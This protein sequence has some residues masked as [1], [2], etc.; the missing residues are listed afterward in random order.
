[1]RSKTVLLFLFSCSL[2]LSCSSSGGG[3]DDRQQVQ[4]PNNPNSGNPDNDVPSPKAA[5]LIFPEHNTECNE[6]TNVTAT[7]SDVNFQWNLAADTDSY[8][9]YVENL[10]SGEV[11]M[12]N[13]SEDNVTMT[14]LRGTPFAWHVVSKASGTNA[15][16]SSSVAQFYNAGAP[17]Q[18]HAPFPAT[19]VAPNMGESVDHG[20]LLLEWA[21]QDINEDIVEHEVFFGVDTPPDTMVGTTAERQWE[22]ATAAQ[23]TYYW[24]II[25][26]DAE[27]NE[28]SSQIFEFRTK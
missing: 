14:I 26:R 13:T 24:Q 3:D 5:T 27:G 12:E 9:V 21:S 19:V 22:V 18:N 8:D 20:V 25:T 10:N 23:T 1:M 17:V 15:T 7:T 6:G 2:L 4:N 28:S 11:V 16:A